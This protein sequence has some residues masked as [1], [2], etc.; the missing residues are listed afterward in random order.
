MRRAIGSLGCLVALAACGDPSSAIQGRIAA[1]GPGAVI[2]GVLDPP[3]PRI[4][5]AALEITVSIDGNPRTI[6]L[7]PDSTFVV[8]EVPIGDIA[9]E[10]SAAGLSARTSFSGVQ[11]GE[12]LGI[13]A[14][15]SESAIDLELL[16]RSKPRAFNVPSRRASIGLE[17]FEDHAVYFLEPGIYNGNL[18]V[19]SSDVRVYARNQD[20]SCDIRQRP[21]VVG[22]IFALGNNIRIDDVGLRGSV[23]ISGKDVQVG[24]SCDGVWRTDRHDNDQDLRPT[25]DRPGGTTTDPNTVLQHGPRDRVTIPPS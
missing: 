15:R 3:L 17:I 4:G 6:Y 12:V 25:V 20:E 16:P 13:L 19:A 7:T 1:D 11:R 24:S 5:Q 22:F 9:V 8:K 23:V 14:H 10:V 21:L 2:A 18:V